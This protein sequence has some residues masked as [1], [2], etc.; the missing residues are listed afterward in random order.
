MI[1]IILAG[2][3]FLGAVIAGVFGFFVGVQQYPE[4]SE[5]SLGLAVLYMAG[6]FVLTL[7]T[8]GLWVYLN[9]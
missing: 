4:R 5:Y 2:L 9:S 8:F 1:L 6:Y 3:W 7:G